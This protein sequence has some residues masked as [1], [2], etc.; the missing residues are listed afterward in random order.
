MD[1]LMIEGGHYRHAIQP[2][3]AGS[4]SN[5]SDGDSAV[6]VAGMTRSSNFPTTPGAFDTTYNGSDAFVAK[7]LFRPEVLRY[8]IYLSLV[9]RDF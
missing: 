3:Q 8:H 1:D 6:Y 9:L 7:L 5:R 2:K 4:P